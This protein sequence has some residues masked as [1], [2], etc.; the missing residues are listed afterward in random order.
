MEGLMLGN[1]R[2]TCNRICPQLV[3]RLRLFD[4][5]LRL[6]NHLAMDDRH[7]GFL[8]RLGQGA[9][10]TGHPLGFLGRGKMILCKL[11][12]V[13]LVLSHLVLKHLGCRRTPDKR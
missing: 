5:R 8:G 7:S 6:R 2:L 12:E 10:F 9:L 11:L 1:N 4:L 3:P 13:L